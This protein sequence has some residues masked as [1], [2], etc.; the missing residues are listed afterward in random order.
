MDAAKIA[1][2]NELAKISKERAL[3]P[4]ELAEQK[5]LR[6]EY[7]AGYRANLRS[8]LGSTKIERPD[9]TREA[10]RPKKKL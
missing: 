10:L 6:E 2:I 3:T 5:A 4:E 9:G 1:R 8:T 7:I